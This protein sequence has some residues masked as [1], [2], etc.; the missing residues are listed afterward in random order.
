VKLC[1]VK[2]L[3]YNQDIPVGAK[4]LS[5]YLLCGTITTVGETLYY[6]NEVGATFYVTYHNHRLVKRP[7]YETLIYNI[8]EAYFTKE[9]DFVFLHVRRDD[10]SYKYL[11]GECYKQKPKEEDHDENSES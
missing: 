5:S 11:V 9:G 3:D 8:D 7:G 6:K 10:Q 2:Y 4:S 1:R